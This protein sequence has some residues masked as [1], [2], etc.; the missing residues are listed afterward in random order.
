MPETSIETGRA[1]D[2]MT[3][4]VATMAEDKQTVHAVRR[5]VAADELLDGML[6]VAQYL[7]D[8]ARTELV[9]TLRREPVGG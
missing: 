2:A 5:E 7:G 3:L 6:S 1:L 9:D 8:R 4:L